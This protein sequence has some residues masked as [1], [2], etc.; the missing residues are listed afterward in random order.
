MIGLLIYSHIL[1]GALVLVLGLYQLI[2]EKG[3]SGH[4]R[5]GRI[6]LLLMWW[7]GISAA[8]VSVYRI[9]FESNY[10]FAFLF[11]IALFSIY[12][13]TS[14]LLHVVVK[15]GDAGKSGAILA[16]M[17]KTIALVM[18]GVAVFLVIRTAYIAALV[19]AVFT[20]IQWLITRSDHRILVRKKWDPRFGEKTWFYTHLSRMIASYIAATTAFLVN[21]VDSGPELVR[22]LGP[23]VAGTLL[24]VLMT[25]HFQKKESL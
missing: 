5:A 3:S 14:G 13:V 2:S 11:V 18:A 17:G 7:T 23:S 8:M 10:S 21:A 16:G 4:R 6:Y 9:F 20:T 25:R 22:W 15:S 1:T 12:L 24:I 19:L